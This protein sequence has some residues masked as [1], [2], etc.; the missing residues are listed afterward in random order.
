AATIEKH[1]VQL[2]A[3][4][5]ALGETNLAP[6]P[7]APVI[8]TMLD[9]AFWASLRKEEGF[10]PRLSLAYLP[11][12]KAVAPLLFETP[13]EFAPYMLAKIGP[14]VGRAGV[15]LGIWQNANGF[16]VWGTTQQIPP[17]CLVLNV[18]EPGLVVV[19]HMRLGGYGKF[20]NVAV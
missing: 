18:P 11:P 6:Q 5:E 16:Y 19:K 20:T 15:H 13:L 14:G 7:P 8:E 12:E 1:F 3:E 9:V 10:S 2:R 4:A 17:V